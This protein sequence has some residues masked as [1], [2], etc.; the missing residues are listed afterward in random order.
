MGRDLF[1]GHKKILEKLDELEKTIKGS[2]V[3]RE[4][5]KEFLDFAESFAESRHQK[6]EE[7]LFPALGKK[8]IPKQGG[9]IGI[10]LYEH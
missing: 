10:M 2:S 1:I 5:I 7:I 9:P 3:D 4:K 6:E 8:G